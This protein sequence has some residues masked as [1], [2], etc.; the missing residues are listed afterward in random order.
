MPPVPGRVAGNVLGRFPPFCKKSEA[1]LPGR[2][3]GSVPAVAPPF[4]SR[5]F[6]NWA[7]EGREPM[8][9]VPGRGAVPTAP[10][11]GRGAV[12]T[13]VPGRVVPVPGR[14]PAMGFEAL[15]G[16]GRD[17]FAGRETFGVDGRAAGRAAGAGRLTDGARAMPPPPPPIRAPPPPP[18]NPP[19]PPRPPPPPPRAYRSAAPLKIKAAIATRNKARFMIAPAEYLCIELRRHAGSFRRFLAND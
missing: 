9:P 7:F 3:A 13:P 12:P 8:A 10:V 11:P 15:G 18:L 4:R 17:T 19:P 2:L 6:C 14:V 16:E 5:K 1:A